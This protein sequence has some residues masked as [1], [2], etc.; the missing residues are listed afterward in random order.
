MTEQVQKTP[1]LLRVITPV[2]LDKE[3]LLS[4]GQYP[5]TRKQIGVP[6]VAGEISWSAPEYSIELSANQMI[7]MGVKHMQNDV[8]MDYDVTK[9]VRSGEVAVL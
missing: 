3:I 2:Q 4:V 1:V 7:A 8:F 5:G 9:H 6:I